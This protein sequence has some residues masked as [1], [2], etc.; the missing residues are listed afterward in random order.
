VNETDEVG[1]HARQQ[2]PRQ[3][4]RAIEP[5]A[6]IAGQA[7]DAPATLDTASLF[8]GRNEVRLLHRGQEYRLRVTKQGKLILTK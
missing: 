7:S 3:P 2:P 4:G 6:A 5:V 8:G 1:L